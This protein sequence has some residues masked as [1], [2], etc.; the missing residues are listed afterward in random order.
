[1]TKVLDGV[2]VLEVA[3]WT[4]VPAAGAVLADWGAD[5]IKVEQPGSGD[6]QRGLVT[7]ALMGGDAANVNY[8]IEQPNRNKRSLTINLKTPGGRDLLL[9]LAARS[10]V[11]LTNWLEPARRKLN[12]DVDD[13]RAV[14]PSIVYVRGSSHGPEGPDSH[15]GSFDSA[16]VWSRSGVASVITPPGDYPV[17]QPAAY[18]DLAGGQ[19][20]AGGIAAALLHRE[21]TGQ[22]AVVDV[23]L[24]GLGMWLMSAEIIS[25]RAYNIT[26]PVP[27]NARGKTPNPLVANY[28]TRDGRYL[29][30]MMLQSD[31][32]WPEFCRTVGRPEWVEQ[33]P[34]AT[35]RYLQRREVIALLDELFA[36]RD[37]AEWRTILGPMEGAWAPV[38]TPYEVAE[39]PQATAN[40]Y[41][42]TVR[43]GDLEFPLITNPVQFDGEA[44]ELRPAPEAGQHTEEIL[45]ELGYN[46]DDIAELSEKGAI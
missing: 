3:A 41:A 8:L 11:F 6:P 38:Q 12:I 21:R 20:I 30:L 23:S 7:S 46:W 31:R 27:R 22:G 44:P 16:A 4:F 19:T 26:S 10:D 5:V 24:L 1:M 17:V 35:A 34:D 36:A 9:A 33:Y 25:A 28:Q 2:R 29:Q 15:K 13:I 37:L 32:Y 14:N 43:K 18:N 42:Q 40:A 39:D 45:L